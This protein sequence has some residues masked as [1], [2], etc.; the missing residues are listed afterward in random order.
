M[1]GRESSEVPTVKGALTYIAS[2][3]RVKN[4]NYAGARCLV[5]AAPHLL[6]IRCCAMCT[7]SVLVA[8]GHTVQ[9]EV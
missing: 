2:A 4:L 8:T 9:S 6:A 1:F 3:D 7:S 5:D